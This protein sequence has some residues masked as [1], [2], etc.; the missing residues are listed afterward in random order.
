MLKTHTCGELTLHHVGQRVTLA[1]WL[2][3]R[4]DHGGV[5]FLDLRDRFGLTQVT[6]DS[7]T[8]PQAHEVAAGAR[9]EYVLQVSG[10]VQPRPAGQE[11][12]QL[13]TGAIEVVADQV[14]ILNPA[15]TPPFTVAEA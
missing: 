11:N 2:N 12:S 1:G 10:V 3:R 8:T 13:A 14:T 15:R 7:A 4:R 5:I 6:V 9:S